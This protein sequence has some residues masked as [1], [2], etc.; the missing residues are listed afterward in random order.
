MFSASASTTFVTP[1]SSL[2]LK[3]FEKAPK[4]PAWKKRTAFHAGLRTIGITK[5][6][7]KEIGYAERPKRVSRPVPRFGAASTG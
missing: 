4:Y 7:A 6:T 5:W 1:G 3:S 2:S